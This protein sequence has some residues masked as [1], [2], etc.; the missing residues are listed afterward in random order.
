MGFNLNEG[1]Y[2]KHVKQKGYKITEEQEEFNI[3]DIDDVREGIKIAAK[4]YEKDMKISKAKLDKQAEIIQLN[5][6]NIENLD[7]NGTR[8]S[9]GEER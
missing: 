7:R 9:G 3:I 6:T 4:Q 1:Y 5:R 2:E 8:V